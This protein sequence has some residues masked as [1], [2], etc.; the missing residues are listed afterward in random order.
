MVKLTDTERISRFLEGGAT[1]PADQEMRYC[2]YCKCKGTVDIPIENQAKRASICSGYRSI[3]GKRRDGN[4]Q[5][6]V[7]RRSK[8]QD[9]VEIHAIGFQRYRHW[10]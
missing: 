8:G 5:R 9:H 10:S 3:A 6:S 7:G 2:P 1:L 4:L